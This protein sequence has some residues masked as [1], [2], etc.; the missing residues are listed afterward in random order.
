MVLEVVIAPII[1]SIMSLFLGLFLEFLAKHSHTHTNTHTREAY[2]LRQ[3]FVGIEGEVQKLQVLVCTI[4]QAPVHRGNL[5]GHIRLLLL[6]EV[7]VI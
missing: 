2:L 5:L 3:R 7:E 4:Q 1:M 6:V